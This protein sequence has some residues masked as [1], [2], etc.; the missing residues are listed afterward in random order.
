MHEF[1]INSGFIKTKKIFEEPNINGYT[2]K[3]IV[4]D[5]TSN[6]SFFVL[7]ELPYQPKKNEDIKLLSFDGDHESQIPVWININSISSVRPYE[8]G[9]NLTKVTY[10]INQSILVISK[11]KAI[12]EKINEIRYNK[13]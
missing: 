5:T 1:N 11:P 6:G 12:I 7:V 10:N 2:S 3:Y 9:S 4:S 13:L 8:L